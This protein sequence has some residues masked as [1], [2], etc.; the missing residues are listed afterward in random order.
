M[1]DQNWQSTTPDTF[2]VFNPNEETV[3]SLLVIYGFPTA[4]PD[5]FGLPGNLLTQDGEIVGGHFSSSES[6]LKRDLCCVGN[7][8]GFRHKELKEQFPNGYRMEYV[9]GED[10]EHHEGLQS[11]IAKHNQA[12]PPEQADAG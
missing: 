6:W 9:H 7:M 11:A 8:N 2:V 3:E 5:N 10:I 12:N 1:T 4:P